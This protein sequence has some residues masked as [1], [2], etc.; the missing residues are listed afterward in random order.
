MVPGGEKFGETITYGI[1][2]VVYATRDPTTHVITLNDASLQANP[3]AIPPPAGA[4]KLDDLIHAP[5]HLGPSRWRNI[6]KTVKKYGRSM[7]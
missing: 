7:I 2:E 5:L 3:V 4:I 1:G 6:T